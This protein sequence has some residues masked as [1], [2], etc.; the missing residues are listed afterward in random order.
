M[1]SVL[2]GLA[3][4]GALSAACSDGDGGAGAGGPGG[5][6]AP[7]QKCVEWQNAI[8]AYAADKCA[9]APK[10][11]CLDDYTAMRCKSDAV[12]QTC[13]DRLATAECSDAPTLV[14]C[15]LQTVVDPQPAIDACNRY[16][17]EACKWLVR[18]GN[19]PSQADCEAQVRAELDCT[20][21]IG[22]DGARFDRC[23]A[24]L[25]SHG[26]ETTSVPESCRGVVKMQS[27]TG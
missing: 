6:P 27:S 10:P 25:A 2:I 23:V 9:A 14:E 16:V 19:S 4:V 13:I 17:G 1:R 18:C 7:T 24:D 15:S 3:A 11:D 12:A 26:C 21:A 8:C 22:V 20:R 5:I